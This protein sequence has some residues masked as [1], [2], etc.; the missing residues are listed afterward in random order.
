MITLAP[1][2]RICGMKAWRSNWKVFPLIEMKNDAGSSKD[3]IAG[4]EMRS[5]CECAWKPNRFLTLCVTYQ[6]KE[7]SQ[8]PRAFWPEQLEGQNCRWLNRGQVYR[9]QQE[10][11]FG[12]C[13]LR[14]LLNIQGETSSVG[15][16]AEPLEASNTPR[17][18]KVRT[19]LENPLSVT[20]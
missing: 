15:E 20:Y 11:K 6:T 7:R 4:E 3:D 14:C 17:G 10:V 2:L 9:W 5:Y 12:T 13:W 18:V 16:K 19:A 8:W 1:V